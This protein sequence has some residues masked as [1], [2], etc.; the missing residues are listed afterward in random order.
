VHGPPEIKESLAL[1]ASSV[2]AVAPPHPPSVS[3]DSEED[4]GDEEPQRKRVKVEAGHVGS[5]RSTGRRGNACPRKRHQKVL[6]GLKE[7]VGSLKAKSAVIFQLAN[8][9][10]A[11]NKQLVAEN[12]RARL[13][14]AQLK[15]KM[16]Q[17]TKS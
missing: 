17:A 12:R 8:A 9:Y 1:P 2:G 3:G 14:N 13:E 7:S 4:D 16:G 6:N 15:E 10:V 5:E 11:E